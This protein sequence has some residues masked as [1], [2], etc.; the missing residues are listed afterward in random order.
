MRF[1]R[2]QWLLHTNI[3]EVNLRQYTAAGTLAAFEQELP[4]LR[5]MGVQTLWFMPLTP[6]SRK[7]RKG[8]LG[9][10]YACSDYCAISQE[11]GTAAD[12]SRLVQTAHQLD[13]KVIIDWVANHTGWDHSWTKLYPSF[14]KTD[15]GTGDF[16]IASGMDDIIE[17]DFTNP[18]LRKAMIAAMQYWLDEFGI[19]GFRCDLAFW[20]E[21][22][23][24]KEARAAL[25]ISKPLFWFGEFDPLEKPAYYEVFD[26]AYTWTWM[27]KTESYCKGE[28]GWDSLQQVLQQYESCCREDDIPVWFT[29]NHDEN[30]WNGTEFEKYGNRAQALAVFSICW[31]GMPL[32][33]SGQELPNTRRLAFFEKDTIQWKGDY[34][35]RDFYSIL[36]RLRREHP[37]LASSGAC[38]RL[39]VETQQADGLLVF[40]RQEGNDQVLVMLNLGPG[41]TVCTVDMEE[42]S[43]RDIFSGEQIMSDNR[44]RFYL[45]SGGYR[46]LEKISA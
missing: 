29:S 43:Y 5:E 24:W 25:D 15:P 35:F 1:T 41:E 44:T 9:S 36:L 39:P 18:G 20:V 38:M 42:G 34:R 12:F 11:F 45:P 8:T 23:F 2:P 22:D 31:K 19:D 30:S 28:I 14:Y 33:Y 6:V 40:A 4:R 37:A 32:I 21:L 13:F 17:L 3:Y 7:N 26:A 10:Y 27:H 16:K 46:V